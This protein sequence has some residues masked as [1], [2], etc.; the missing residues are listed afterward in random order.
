MPEASKLYWRSGM[1]VNLRLQIE[2]SHF[3]IRHGGE[4]EARNRKE[5]LHHTK[6]EPQRM[7]NADGRLNTEEKNC[8]GVMAGSHRGEVGAGAGM[9]VGWV[10]KDPQECH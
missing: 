5:S 4:A 9:G 7:D 2:R 10:G 3:T 1:V 8:E 6:E